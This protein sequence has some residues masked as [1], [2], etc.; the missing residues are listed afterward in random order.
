VRFSLDGKYLATGCNFYAQ[1]YDVD[2][3]AKL[4]TLSDESFPKGSGDLFIRTVCF[5]PDGKSLATGCEDRLIRIW[6]IAS[7]KMKMSW[8]GHEQD[9]YSLDWSRDGRTIVSG[10]G[11]RTVK[12]AHFTFLTSGLG[13]CFWTMRSNYFE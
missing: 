11:D 3:G 9:I 12:V 6:D 10:S 8:K 7:Q 13:Y 1:I 5:S 4:C 2:T